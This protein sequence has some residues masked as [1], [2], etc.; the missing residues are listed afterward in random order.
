MFRMNRPFSIVRAMA[1]IGSR[2]RRAKL[3]FHWEVKATCIELKILLLLFRIKHL[4]AMLVGCCIQYT[5]II[6]SCEARSP[7]R[8]SSRCPRFVT[9]SILSYLRAVLITRII[10]L[11]EC[12]LDAAYFVEI[13]ITGVR[14]TM[15]LPFFG[16]VFKY[17]IL[18]AYVPLGCS[19]PYSRYLSA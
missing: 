17:T 14:M 6:R 4:S 1:D 3:I 10:F 7:C 19:L 9:S 18:N 15:S 11:V 8:P 5:N 16:A 12:E 2:S 13:I